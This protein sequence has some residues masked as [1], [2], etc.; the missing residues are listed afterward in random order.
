MTERSRAIADLETA[1]TNLVRRANTPRAQQQL[2]D[3]AGVAL[4]RALHVTL[5]R[6]GVAGPIRLGELADELGVDISTTSRQVGALE[7]SGLVLRSPASDDR[8]VV[9]VTIT[10]QGRELLA[11][12]LAARR[13]LLADLLQDWTEADMVAFARMLERFVERLAVPVASRAPSAP[14]S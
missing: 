8:R 4:D 3:R 12:A 2:S 9:L 5:A 1:L 13:E 6:V 7:E 14:T 11:R 10:P